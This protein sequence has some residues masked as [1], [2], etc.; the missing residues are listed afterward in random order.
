MMV[1]QSP[2]RGKAPGFPAVG[3]GFSGGATENP[4]VGGGKS[5]GVEEIPPV[6]GVIE[7]LTITLD[8]F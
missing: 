3:D 6:P 1:S 7:S 2:L 4:S 8:V 5:I